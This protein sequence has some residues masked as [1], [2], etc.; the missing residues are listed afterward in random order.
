MGMKAHLTIEVDEDVLLAARRR[1]LRE[2]TSVG[3]VL[4][5]HLAEY[6]DAQRG[7]TEAVTRL[8]ELSR[9]AG[10]AH[11]DAEWSRDDLY[12]RRSPETDEGSRGEGGPSV[13]RQPSSSMP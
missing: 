1:A 12:G 6:A 4:E 2:G 9:T 10:A 8:L 7:Q 13:E 3:A 11:G 5:R